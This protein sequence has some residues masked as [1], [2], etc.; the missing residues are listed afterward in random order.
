MDEAR[1]EVVFID[2]F[3]DGAEA[4]LVRGRVRRRFRL[5][6]RAF[7]RIT[8]GSPVVVKR[9]RELEEARR[10][11]SVIRALG[12]VCWIQLSEDDGRHV[13]RRS[14]QRRALLD[15]RAIYRGSSILPDRRG[16][17][18]RRSSDRWFS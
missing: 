6:D 5:S 1:Y 18:G 3:S 13:E 14:I 17:C 9:C 12:A 16:G 11:L 2:K 15:R 7:A 4:D 10:Y 8:S